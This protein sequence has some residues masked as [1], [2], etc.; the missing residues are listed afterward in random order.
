MEWKVDKFIMSKSI[1]KCG[2]P[3]RYDADFKECAVKP[4]TEGG[5]PVTDAA[6]ELGVSTDPCVLGSKT[7]M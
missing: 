6:K 2:T 4:V 1:P 5:R 3:P 7:P